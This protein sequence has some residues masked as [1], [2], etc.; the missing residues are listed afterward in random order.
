MD[1]D[2]DD[3][4]QPHLHRG[5]ARRDPDRAAV[6][7]AGRPQPPAGGLRHRAQP[8]ADR[9]RRR[10]PAARGERQD[11]RRRPQRRL[12]LRR[13]RRPLQRP[14]HQRLPRHQPARPLAPGRRRGPYLRRLRQPRGRPAGPDRQL[15]R[16]HRRPRRRSRPTSRPRSN[17]LAPTLDIGRNSLVSLN[18]TL[19]PLR[20]Y[21]IELTPGG[22]RAAGADRGGASR[23][24]PRRGRCS[25]ARRAVASPGCSPNRLRASPAPPRRARRSRCRSS[26][27]SASAPPRSS[28]PTGN[29]TIER[30]LQHRRPNYRE[31]FYYLVNFAGI[32]PELRR[33]RPLPARCSPAAA[34][35]WSSRRTPAG[36]LTHRQ[37]GLGSHGRRRR[38]ACSR[39]S[40]A[41]RRRSPTCAATPTPFPTSTARSA[42]PARPASRR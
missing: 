27:G 33:Q 40:A 30:P 38:S 26:T 18:R 21:A 11:R 8:Q 42:S 15:Q 17:R 35:R 36:N 12:P 39:S 22:G 34:P 23:G 19:P 16:L 13:R 41:G 4:G 7:R 6:A 20:A 9:G 29:Q 5:P 31:F 24:S 28:C 32:G 37:T 3:P 10:D 2:G 25:P 1:S 14:G